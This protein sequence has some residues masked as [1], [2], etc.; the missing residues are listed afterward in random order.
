MKKKIVFLTL[1]LFFTAN[2]SYSQLISIKGGPVIGF[3]APSSDYGGETSDFYAGTK[4]GLKSGFNYGV[5]GKVSFGPIGGRLSIG[6]ATLNNDGNSDPTQ[7]NST[8]AVKNNIFSFSIGA[9]FG[10]TIPFTPVRPY[11]DIDLLFSTISGTYNFQGTPEVTS[12]ERNIESASRTG[13]GLALGTEI[14]FGKSFTLDLSLR[15]NLLNLFSKSY[16]GVTASN[17]RNFAYGYINDDADPNYSATNSKHPIGSSRT[18]A[19]IQ[20][21]AGFLF[22]F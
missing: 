13:L 1:V 5:M 3:T 8:V 18:I 17:D 2:Y 9:E 19:T 10:F 12:G 15:Y 14:G 11:A 20:F 16:D 7:P 22:G 21:N 6:Y 4:Y